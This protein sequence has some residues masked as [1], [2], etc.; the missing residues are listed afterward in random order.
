MTTTEFHTVSR[1]HYHSHCRPSIIAFGVMVFLLILHR[2]TGGRFGF[3]FRTRN[4]NSIQVHRIRGWFVADCFCLVSFSPL[5]FL[6]LL[7]LQGN[8][9]AF[10]L[11]LLHMSLRAT[12]K[13]N[14]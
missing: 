1:F 6:I 7:I 11:Y 3:C 13:K 2:S 14:P 10:E 4:S 5:F 9:V 8:V 12:A